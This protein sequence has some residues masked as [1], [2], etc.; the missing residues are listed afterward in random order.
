MMLKIPQWFGISTFNGPMKSIPKGN[1]ESAADENIEFGSP[2]D[3]F[4][5]LFWNVMRESAEAGCFVAIEVFLSDDAKQTL[6]ASI[7]TGLFT[8][9]GF[10]LLWGVGG[11]FMSVKPFAIL[12]AVVIQM[13]AVGLFTGSVHAFEEVHYES[14]GTEE[15]P[16]VWESENSELKNAI[17]VFAFFGLQ[18]SF[19]ALQ[20]VAWILSA[21]VLTALQLHHNYYGKP[22]P[23]LKNHCGFKVDEEPV[24]EVVKA[25]EI[26]ES[27]KEFNKV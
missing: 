14:T 7:V 10:S 21:A 25:E 16:A 1:I 22:L 9:I 13:L 20:F 4:F 17:N 11:L 5:N 26:L 27:S 15:I 23:S 6:G 12:A 19:T 18:G 3:F 24:V 8:A 2:K